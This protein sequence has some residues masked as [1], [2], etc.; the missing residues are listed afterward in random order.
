M[1]SAGWT[2]PHI[3]R[4]PR[5]RGGRARVEGQNETSGVLLGTGA[6][7]DTSRAG[8]GGLALKDPWHIR[9]RSLSRNFGHQVAVSAGL[10]ITR[11]EIVVIIDDD[12]RGFEAGASGASQRTGHFGLIGIRERAAVLGGRAEIESGAGGTSVVVALPISSPAA[13]PSRGMSLT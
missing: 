5:R 2:G 11:G 1:P 3:P 10:D 13:D 4:T 8:L 9:S 7:T 6:S 12:G